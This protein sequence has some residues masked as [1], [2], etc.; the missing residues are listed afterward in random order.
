MN[1]PPF[2]VTYDYRCPFARNAHEHLFAALRNGAG[3]EVDLV[4]FSLSQTHVEEADEPVWE[5]PGKSADLI[6]MEASLVVKELSPEAFGEVHLDLFAARH[7]QGRDL[8]SEQ[9]IRDVLD[10]H[11]VD[12]SEVFKAIADGWPRD[13]F[14]KA[15][16]R[17]VADHAVF[18][19]PTF[20]VG[21]D[22]VFVR[23]MTRP[24]GDPATSKSL[25]ERIVS[26]L[27]EHPELN[28]VKH[29][30]VSN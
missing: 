1:L 17:A 4:P 5:D 13:S 27:V 22:A 15:H 10:A 11:G 18:G 14:R 3:W 23:I 9:V 25:I 21:G 16:E 7:D 24:A 30:T 2:A 28:E 12:S 20:V 19:V 8:R 29:T 26:L 6:A